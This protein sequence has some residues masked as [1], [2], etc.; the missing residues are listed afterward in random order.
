MY[1][2]LELSDK[3][4]RVLFE[5]AAE[6]DI[7][8]FTSVFDEE[9]V[10]FLNELGAPAFKIASGDITYLSLIRKAACTGKPVMISTGMS[11]LDEVAA[12]IGCCRDAG[13][14]DVV[15]FHCSCMYPPPDDEINLNSMITMRENF[16]VPVGYSD[17]TRGTAVPVAAVAIGASI[18]EKHFTLDRSMPGPDHSLSLDPDNFRRMVE[19]IRTVEKAKGNYNKEPSPGE[20]E[21]LIDGRRGIMADADIPAGTIITRE[22]LKILKPAKGLPPA[23]IDLIVGRR[24][25]KDIKKQQP[26]VIDLIEGAEELCETT[27]FAKY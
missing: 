8:C 17:H 27:I 14:D 9:R 10:D 6:R 25:A 20:R 3:H 18:I 21:G 2:N 24:A 23:Y 11:N 26:I 22:M 4:H 7:V 5:F 15:L 19:D 16:G 13:N 1:K 12:A